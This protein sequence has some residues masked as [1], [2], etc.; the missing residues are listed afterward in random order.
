MPNM[1]MPYIEGPKLDWRANYGGY[2]HFL[3]WRLK[4]KNILECE[5]AALQEKQ[6]CKKVIVWSRDFGMDQ[7]VSWGLPKEKL[8]LDTIWDRFEEFCKPQ[9][10]EVRAHFDF[11]QASTRATKAWMSGTMLYKLRSIWPGTP[12]RLPRSCIMTYSGSS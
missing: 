2:H 6:Q 5:L 7:Y 10:N 3:K 12:L 9:S 4:C 11:S 1:Y 8:N